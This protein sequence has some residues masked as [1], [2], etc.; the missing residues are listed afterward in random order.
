MSSQF[1]VLRSPVQEDVQKQHY[2]DPSNNIRSNQ[3]DELTTKRVGD[4]VNNRDDRAT[5]PP[6]HCLSVAS[7]G[8]R[9]YWLAASKEI[10]FTVHGW[11]DHIARRIT[12]N[13]QL[14]GPKDVHTSSPRVTYVKKRKEKLRP[15]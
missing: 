7:F 5:Q 6:P 11:A 14:R 4:F 13:K 2:P 12:S 15:S 10:L 3:A 9:A 1:S 8:K